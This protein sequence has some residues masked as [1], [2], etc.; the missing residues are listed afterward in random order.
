[1]R[2]L[3]MSATTDA[4]SKP[5]AHCRGRCGTGCCAMCVISAHKCF[6]RDTYEADGGALEPAAPLSLLVNRG[7][8]SASE[9]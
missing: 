7:T 9:V 6:C 5:Q 1:M 4:Q 2:L 3:A 8:A